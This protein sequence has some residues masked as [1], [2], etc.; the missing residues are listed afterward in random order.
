MHEAWD[1][2]MNHV[3]AFIALRCITPVDEPPS[4][5]KAVG[6]DNNNDLGG[7]VLV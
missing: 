7:G 2:Y 5:L 6:V 3:A 1:A 4:L